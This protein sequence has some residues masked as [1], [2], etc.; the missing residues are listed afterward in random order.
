MQNKFEWRGM[1]GAGYQYGF[2]KE[3]GEQY[4]LDIAVPG[5]GGNPKGMGH[6]IYVDGNEV[7]SSSSL[8]AAEKFLGKFFAK[9]LHKN[10]GREESRQRRSLGEKLKSAVGLG[11]GKGRGGR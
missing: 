7:G 11:A 9:G 6:K 3:G 10:I 8:E 4:R 2:Y 5:R 1:D